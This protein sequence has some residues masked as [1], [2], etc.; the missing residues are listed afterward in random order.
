LCNSTEEAPKLYGRRRIDQAVII[1]IK[2]PAEILLRAAYRQH[3]DEFGAAQA[4][5]TRR[6][7]QRM[8]VRLMRHIDRVFRPRAG[9]E[10]FPALMECSKMAEINHLIGIKGS[11]GAV[12]AAIGTVEGLKEWWT[13][14]ASGSSEVGETIH[15]RFCKIGAQDMKV[16]ELRKDTL[17]R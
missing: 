11:L 8:A 1:E 13:A 4:S 16:T 15:F 2:L 10:V 6:N 9:A 7:S 17:V 3:I 5:R 12:Y 14:D